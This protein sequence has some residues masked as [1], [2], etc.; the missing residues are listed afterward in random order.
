MRTAFFYLPLFIFPLISSAQTISPPTSGDTTLTLTTAP[1]PVNSTISI[2]TAAPPTVCN[3]SA[4]VLPLAPNTSNLVIP[5]TNTTILL[6]SPLTQGQIVCAV[7]TA[8]VGAAAGGTWN[9]PPVTVG[10]PAS[11]PGYDWGMVQAYFTFGALLSEQDNQ[12]SHE[13]LFLSFHLDKTYLQTGNYNTTGKHSFKPGLNTFFDTRLTSLPVSV[14]PC[15]TSSGSSSTCSNANTSTSSTSTSTSSTTTSNTQVFLNSQKTARFE[16]GIYAPFIWNRWTVSNKSNGSGSNTPYA[17][18][19]APLV[20]TGFDTSVNGL[21]QIQ[22]QSSTPDSVQPVGNSASFYKFYDFGFR[23]GQY[24]LSGQKDASHEILSLLDVAWGRFS[25]MASLLCP[26]PLYNGNGGCGSSATPAPSPLPWSHDWRVSLEGLL[27]VPAT[28]GF[29][30]GFSA[31]VSAKGTP[32]SVV[33]G[34]TDVHIR[35]QDDL[36]FLFAYKIDIS[37]LAAKLAPQ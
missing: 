23:L 15:S 32:P 20:K 7:L 28:H 3:S 24:Q 10:A 35:P 37:Q 26:V 4:T 33:N 6:K 14:Q 36:R 11:P 21:N 27:E 13:D 30:V 9:S 25:N 1:A 5:G 29:S 34:T 12:F 8:P 2:Y 19:I 31:N 17:L 22:Q 16:F 18:Y